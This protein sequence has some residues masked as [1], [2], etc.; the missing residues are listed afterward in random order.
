MKNLSVLSKIGTGMDKYFSNAKLN[1]TKYSPEILMGL[2]VASIIGGFVMGCKA[3]LKAHEVLDKHDNDME[4]IHKAEDVSRDYAN[5]EDSI[6]DKGLAKGQLIIGM[7]KLYAPS[8]IFLAGGIAMICASHGIMKKRNAGLMAAYQAVDTA[9]RQY[10]E[11]V[12]KEEGALKDKHYATG[13]DYE[14]IKN[15]ETGEEEIVKTKQ[16]EKEEVSPSIYAKFF[17]ESSRYWKKDAWANLTFLKCV[18]AQLNNRLN[19]RGFL[20]LNEV[21]EA[22]DIDPTPAGQL[23]GWTTK[24]E[25]TYIDLG[26]YNL[27]D[28][29]KRAFI[30]GYERSILIEPNVQGVV[31]DL[32]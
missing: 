28:K 24:K 22:L 10:R 14:V 19:T 12:V 11:R 8:I 2:G 31:Y 9:Y 25:G 32:I 27:Y 18:Q 23:V 15:P 4:A 7:A 13:A 20:F 1:I 30:N 5:G 16:P 26:I 6:R 17:D 3:T 29:Q 21:Y